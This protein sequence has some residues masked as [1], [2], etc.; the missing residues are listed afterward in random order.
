[1]KQKKIRGNPVYWESENGFVAVTY[2]VFGMGS[3]FKVY[4]KAYYH[5]DELENFMTYWDYVISFT[6]VGEAIE[7][8][9]RIVD[10]PVYRNKFDYNN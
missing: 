1:M 8:A 4:R 5:Q 9:K 7:Y 3:Q 6:F 10:A 2:N